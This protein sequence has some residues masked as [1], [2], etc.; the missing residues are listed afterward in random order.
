MGWDTVLCDLHDLGYDVRWTLLRAADVGAAHNRARL[1]AVAAD[2]AVHRWATPTGWPVAR[3]ADGALNAPHDGLFG[4]HP[5]PLAE[6]GHVPM[7]SAGLMMSGVVWE[8]DALLGT[9]QYELLP[10]PQAHDAVGGKTPEQVAA[11]RERTGAGVANLNEVAVNEL[12][13]LFRTPTAQLAV[14]GGSQHPDKR[15]DG[16]HGPTLADEIEHLLPTPEASDGT[17]GRVSAVRGGFR[18]SGAKRSVSLAT[19][20]AHDLLPTPA[21][22]DMGKAYTPEEWDVWCDKQR[23]AHGNGNGHG[24]SLEIEA[25]RMAS[26]DRWG[27]YAAAV[28]RCEALTRPAPDPTLPSGKGGASRLSPL[29]VEF[30]MMLPTGWVTDPALWTHLSASAAR[31]VQLKLLGNGCVT[32]QAAAAWRHL[33]SGLVTTT[34]VTA[35]GT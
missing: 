30:L 28:A 8:Q 35:L 13:P 27:R 34:Q 17:G 25:A 6:N 24:P 22:N 2:R 3:I 15:K 29:F 16:G 7:W 1:F 14:N 4:A 12:E 32:A 10:T 19:A 9:A 11:M 18:P 26:G 33:T 23:A 20:L 21:V 31:N 5:L